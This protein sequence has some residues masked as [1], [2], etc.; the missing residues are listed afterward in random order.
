ARGNPPPH[1]ARFGLL[2]LRHFSVI[3]NPRPILIAQFGRFP[4]LTTSQEASASPREGT[5]WDVWRSE[6][7]WDIWQCPRCNGTL[8][9]AQDN[10]AL[11]TDNPAVACP[12]CAANYRVEDNILVLKD[13]TS[14]NNLVAREFYDSPLWPKFR[15]WEKVTWFCNGGE[16]RARNQVL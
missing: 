9:Y 8:K 1:L 6:P 11:A 13:Q 10:P 3:E 12:A 5:H 4:M 16:H 2:H 7:W 14:A 15:F